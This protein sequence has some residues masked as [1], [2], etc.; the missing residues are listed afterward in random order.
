MSDP[1]VSFSSRDG[2]GVITFNRPPANAYNFGFHE[3]FNAA[4]AAADADDS[5]RVVI[6]RS[7]LERFFCAGADIKEFAS[8]S[9]DDNKRMVD[10]ARRA[11][12]AIEASGKL[13]I[14]CLQGHALGGGLEIAMACDLRF[15]AEGNF[16]LGL[17]ET[18]LGLLPGNGGSQRLPRIVGASQALALLA[19]GESIA[20]QEA[21]RIG[22]IDR[23]F[24]AEAIVAETE[25]FA[26]QV[27]S[28]APLAVAAS[29]RAVNEGLDLEFSESLALEA[30]LVDELYETEDAKEGFQSFVEKRPPNYQGR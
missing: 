22:L 23:L 26:A 3:E 25:S 13:F 24:S 8:N 11:L 5:T 30:R 28:S 18:K 4:I 6:L 17:P 21:A 27:A 15:G 19:S 7:A 10:S 2:I 16:K 1:L 9:T 14:A 29:K 20:P 12:A